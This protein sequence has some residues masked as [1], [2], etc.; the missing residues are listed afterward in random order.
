MYN[1]PAIFHKTKRQ[2]C[3]KSNRIHF[4]SAGLFNILQSKKSFFHSLAL[5]LPVSPAAS[6]IKNVDQ[7][8]RKNNAVSNNG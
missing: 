3:L 8:K 1:A 7:D 2:R 4:V 6:A 5:I